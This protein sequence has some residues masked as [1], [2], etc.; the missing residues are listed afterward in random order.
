MA[1]GQVVGRHESIADTAPVPIDQQVPFAGR[2]V[3]ALEHLVN[4]LALRDVCVQ[5]P[6]FGEHTGRAL[7]QKGTVHRRIC[8]RACLTFRRCAIANARLSALLIAPESGRSG[9]QPH[10]ML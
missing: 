7:Q 10:V 2:W 1:H 6:G 5:R 4:T 9:R 3:C 8:A